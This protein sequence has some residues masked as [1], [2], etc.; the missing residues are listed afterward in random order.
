MTKEYQYH[1]RTSIYKRIRIVETF[2]KICILICIVCPLHLNKTVESLFTSFFMS[3][4][5]IYLLLFYWRY[6]MTF[7]KVLKIYHSWIPSF[8]IHPHSWNNFIRSHFSIYIHVYIIFQQYSPSYNFPKSSLLLVPASQMW[9]VLPFSCLFLKIK[10][11]FC[12]FMIAIQG[13]SLW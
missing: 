12:L 8:C 5:F 13:V 10:R 7:T 2:T 4:L 11:H 3:I 9:T 6:I 1:L